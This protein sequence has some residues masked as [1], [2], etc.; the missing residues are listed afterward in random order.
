MNNSR[1]FRIEFTLPYYD[2]KWVKLSG[3]KTIFETIDEAR[4]RCMIMGPVYLTCGDR[5]TRWQQ[6]ILDAKTGEVIEHVHSFDDL[7]RMVESEKESE[8]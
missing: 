6:R 1:E 7:E 8:Q 2:G 5:Q 4:A 3:N